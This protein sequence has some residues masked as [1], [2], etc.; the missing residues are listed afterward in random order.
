MVDIIKQF[1]DFV[2]YLDKSIEELV[3]Y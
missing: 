3:H 2:N 1:L